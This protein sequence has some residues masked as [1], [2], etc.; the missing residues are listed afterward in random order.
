MVNAGPADEE[1]PPAN[2]GDPHPFHGPVVPGEPDLVA[3]IA[4][5]FMENLPQQVINMQVTDQESNANSAALQDDSATA[6]LFIQGQNQ[7]GEIVIEEDQAEPMATDNAGDKDAATVNGNVMINHL[8]QGSEDPVQTQQIDSMD[9]TVQFDASKQDQQLVTQNPTSFSQNMNDESFS[10][11]ATLLQQICS[12]AQIRIHSTV[13]PDGSNLFTHLSVKLPGMMEA[14]IQIP[15]P[16]FDMSQNQIAHKQIEAVA[17]VPNYS[18]YKKHITK[19]YHRRGIKA[20]TKENS[21]GG[22]PGVFG[23]L[24]DDYTPVVQPPETK[25]VIGKGG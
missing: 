23:Q 8:P 15:K 12:T 11:M 25:L 9:Q 20:R 2:N 22:S 13:H 14:K 24:V 4:E 6:P 5:Q 3:H 17:P 21:E 1:D 10:G 19:V 18:L 16:E 7:S